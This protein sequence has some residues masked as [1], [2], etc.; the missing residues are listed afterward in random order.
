[1]EVESEFTEKGGRNERDE[2]GQ[3]IILRKRQDSKSHGSTNLNINKYGIWTVCH[4]QLPC[5][6]L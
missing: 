2:K 4:A 6:V 1:M 5:D 3:T